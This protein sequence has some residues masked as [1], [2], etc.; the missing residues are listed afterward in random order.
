MSVSKERRTVRFTDEQ[1]AAL[2]KRAADEG[3]SM[4]DIIHRLIDEPEGLADY[5]IEYRAVPREGTIGHPVAGLFGEYDDV[6]ELFPAMNWRIQERDVSVWYEAY[7][8]REPAVEVVSDEPGKAEQKVRRTV[9]FTDEQ[10]AALGKRAADEGE[11]VT[12]VIHRLV[13]AYLLEDSDGLPGYTVEYRA[14]LAGLDVEILIP[15]VAGDYQKLRK[16][17]PAPWSLQERS[18]SSWR[19]AGA[20]RRNAAA[21]KKAAAPARRATKRVSR[22]S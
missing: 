22:R 6:R 5:S 12:D 10:W 14:V 16:L 1:W 8:R 9:R 15:A 11:S 17:F 21:P 7:S 19:E 3:E 2:G 13:A 20:R 18:V 4:T